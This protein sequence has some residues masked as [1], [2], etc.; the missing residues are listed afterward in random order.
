VSEAIEVVK[1]YAA[2]A[3]RSMP[4]DGSGKSAEQRLAKL[5]ELLDPEVRFSVPKSLPYGGEYVGHAGFLALGEGFGKT[6]QVLDNGAAGYTDL[7]ENRV[8]G[9]Y[10]PTFKSVVTGRTVSFRVC[11]ILSVKDGRIAQ[12]TP[13]YSDTVELVNAVTP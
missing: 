8:L 7:G 3:T 5:L 12:L 1:R 9:L 11:E 4:D 13:Y 6:W 10:N 2:T